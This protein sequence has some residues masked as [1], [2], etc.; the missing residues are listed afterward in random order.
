MNS[1]EQ[2]KIES[3]ESEMRV[4]HLRVDSLERF[5][6][7]LPRPPVRPAAGHLSIS[8]V[9]RA[10]GVSQKTVRRYSGIFGE[11]KQYERRTE[12]GR[13]FCSAR[14]LRKVRRRDWQTGEREGDW[15]GKGGSRPPQAMGITNC[16]CSVCRRRK[17]VLLE[18][19][20]FVALAGFV[21]FCAICGFV[22]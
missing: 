16:R 15:R 22:R 5:A 17:R 7:G 8:D 14:R 13:I 3:L 19:A 21:L 10:C 12:S 20:L 1:P 4:L 18:T 2:R 11:L 9:A 6:R